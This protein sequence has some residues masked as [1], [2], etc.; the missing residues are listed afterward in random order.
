MH[1]LTGLSQ[2]APQ[3]AWQYSLGGSLL[4][5]LRGAVICPDGGWVVVGSSRSSDYDIPANKN[6]DDYLIAR[7]AADGT[8]KWVRTY[9]GNRGETARTVMCT[10]DGGFIV[11]G[12]TQSQAQDVGPHNGYFDIWILKLDSLGNIVWKKTFGGSGFDNCYRVIPSGSN[13]Y[14]TGF[15]ESVDG[16]G[17]GNHGGRDMV[18]AKINSSG[19][20]VWQKV[21]GGSLNEE[22]ACLLETSSGNLLVVGF[23]ES[24]DG[25]LTGNMGMRDYWVLMLD[26]NGNIQWQKNYGGNFDDAARWVIEPEPNRFVICGFSYSTNGHRTEALG[27]YDFWIIKIDHNGN[28]I[29]QKSLGGSGYDYAYHISKTFDG[30]YLVSGQTYSSDQMVSN[31]KGAGDYW[32][33][34][35]DTNGT[36]LW[37]KIFGGSKMDECRWAEQL[38]TNEWLVVGFSH[39]S[40]HDV[41][42]QKGNGDG[43]IVR[44]CLSPLPYY[45]DLDGDGFGNSQV[46]LTACSLPAGFVINNLDCDDTNAQITPLAVE[47][48]DGLDNN[49]N[50]L[51]DDFS[52]TFATLADGP[53]TFCSSEQRKLSPENVYNFT[54]IQ[55]YHN[56]APLNGANSFDYFASV[57]GTYFAVLSNAY[58]DVYTS[59]IT[60]EVLGSP[61]ASVIQS[62]PTN[63]CEDKNVTLEAIP[64]SGCSYQWSRDG[65]D[66]AGATQSTYTYSENSSASFTVR[67]TAANSCTATSLPVSVIKNPKPEA[68]ITPLGNLDICATGSVTLQASQAPGNKYKWYKDNVGINGAKQSAYTA[69]SIG[70]YKVKVT[71]SAKCSKTSQPVTV[72]ST[73]RSS[74]DSSFSFQVFPNPSNGL[75][76]AMINGLGDNSFEVWISDIAGRKLERLL[77]GSSSLDRIYTLPLPHGLAAGTY[78]INLHFADKV[79]AV[80]HLLLR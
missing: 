55:W 76:Y 54:A 42:L 3:I 67:V 60:L 33:S 12:N 39:S 19:V 9:G 6:G 38:N 27:S 56:G 13:Y 35:M 16:M 70:S 80:P 58:C 72:Y 8:L 22:A 28:L 10:S 15:T 48:C 21:L 78:L 7:F 46:S 79:V 57:S 63:S 74:P 52:L 30:K 40:D 44:A 61:Q 29:W 75:L 69:T 24:A 77:A 2:T 25:N 23:S 71:S 34:L 36:F 37:G 1:G 73:C 65:S 18:V 59:S 17:T 20:L 26:P 66:I 62:S 53:T 43:W 31:N 64:C 49:C 47:W 41:A 4:E 51:V 45:Q 68:I 32:V 5:E 14:F 50:G 11:G